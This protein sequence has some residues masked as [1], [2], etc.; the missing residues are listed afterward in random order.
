MTYF[1]QMLGSKNLGEAELIGCSLCK[2]F[3]RKWT[4]ILCMDSWK[5]T[6]SLQSSTVALKSHEYDA[7]CV[8]TGIETESSYR[9][10]ENLV[11][12]SSLTD[13]GSVHIHS[14]YH[15]RALQMGLAMSGLKTVV[16]CP[17]TGDGRRTP[18]GF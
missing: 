12:F 3:E 15:Y 16:Q 14:P 11:Q 1:H 10:L 6:S 9:Q 2:I 8:F 7:S 17:S 18:M 13:L 4:E 5:R